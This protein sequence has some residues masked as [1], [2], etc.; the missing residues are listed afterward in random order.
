MS[1]YKEIN[2]DGEN[3]KEFYV[4]PIVEQEMSA[5]L[6]SDYPWSFSWAKDNAHLLMTSFHDSGG[7]SDFTKLENVEGVPDSSKQA[8]WA[9]H[10]KGMIFTSVEFQTFFKFIFPA[11]RYVS[12]G[13]MYTS[14][15]TR[16]IKHMDKLLSSTKKAILAA[17]NLSRGGGGYEYESPMAGVFDQS[18]DPS[19]F[20]LA[21]YNMAGIIMKFLIK[22]PFMILKGVA[23]TADPNIIVAKKIIEILQF[24]LQFYKSVDP[25]C[26]QVEQLEA[27]LAAIPFPLLS[28]GLL[29]SALP[30][31]V[32]FPPPPLGP[33]IG[34]PMTPFG[35]A[36]LAFGLWDN[37]M[38]NSMD[39]YFDKKQSDS[40]KAREA[41]K[42]Q[43]K[44]CSEKIEEIL[45][46]S[47]EPSE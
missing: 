19:K 42:E 33:G 5:N 18:D 29:P 11:E 27:L 6:W 21:D 37:S 10:L 12:M 30:Y 9:A 38:M 17:H 36:Y 43:N 47:D 13:S 1:M 44:E 24:M 16:K 14:F 2:Y 25:A 7:L 32:G 39:E 20:G 46:I 41:I 22:T 31:G 40:D 45:Y 23:E 3:T 26:P 4:I 35:P 28:I 15:A 8:P 34:P